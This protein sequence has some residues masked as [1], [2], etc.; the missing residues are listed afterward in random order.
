[1]A[2]QM[3][4]GSSSSSVDVNVVNGKLQK[5]GTNVSLEG[6]THGQYLTS[7]QTLYDNNVNW[8]GTQ[9]AGGI[10]PIDAG[11]TDEF[12]HNKLAFLPPQCIA[13]E[14]SRDGGTTWIDYG[15]TDSQKTALVTTTGPSLTVGCNPDVSTVNGTLTESNYK[16]YKLRITL[17]TASLADAGK[18]NYATYLY[19]AA[20]K[21]LV[22][23]STTG[24]QGVGLDIYYRKVGDFNTNT[25]TWVKY[26]TTQ[27]KL[28]G[29][30][31]WNSIPLSLTFGGSPSQTTNQCRD[32][33]LIFDIYGLSSTSYSNIVSISDIRMIGITNWTTC[34]E[35]ARA[36]HMYTFDTSKNVTFPA[37]VTATQFNGALSGNATTATSIGTEAGVNTSINRLGIG[38]SDPQDADYYIAQYSGGGTTTTTYHRRP[39]SALWNYI[40]GKI[41]S[42]LGLT[43]T[44][45]GGKAATAGTADTANNVAWANTNHPTFATVATSGSYND[46]S[47]KPS[48]PT[49]PTNVS[50]FT[51]DANYITQNIKVINGTSGLNSTKIAEY[52]T[53]YDDVFIID[54]DRVY[55]Y[56]G[57][58]SSAYFF[59]CTDKTNVYAI[60]VQSS[61]VS[62]SS[63][64]IPTKASSYTPTDSTYFATGAV[65]KAALDTLATVASSG[66]YNDLANQ[67]T[68]PSETTVEQV[69]TSGTEI[70]KVNGT[71]LFAPQG[72]G[73]VPTNVVL[74]D[75]N[76]NVLLQNDFA[77][78]GDSTFSGDIYIDDTELINLY[79]TLGLI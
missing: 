31:G 11:C 38:S 17:G 7:H 64:V 40:K 12:G 50:A 36:G 58:S 8:G 4:I 76:G 23:V 37:Q 46:L 20:R 56:F 54:S 2:K 47:N 78:N 75:N 44:N 57:K 79:T 49:V 70:A 67:P 22:N 29:W 72:G 34:N 77:V 10:S 30:S 24:A 43:A 18:S 66:D 3:N 1:M 28:T 25:N 71:S 48:I 39:H 62:K 9:L 61:G 13:V 73:S 19:T 21:L 33:R 52:L 35:L 69:L 14:Y 51:N 26:N 5:G 60:D 16:N 59:R 74:Y 27:Y 32:M 65:V 68:I 55:R 63:H 42:V 41:S 6:H 15:L 53:N 45:Y